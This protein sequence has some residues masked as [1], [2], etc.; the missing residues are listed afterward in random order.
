MTAMLDNGQDRHTRANVTIDT[1]QNQALIRLNKDHEDMQFVYD[2]FAKIGWLYA[3][4]HELIHIM[5]YK[6]SSLAENMINMVTDDEQNCYFRD[7]LE[8]KEESTV[9][10]LT[11]A[12]IN[13]MG[14]DWVLQYKRGNNNEAK[15]SRGCKGKED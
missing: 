8:C 6:M 4:I 5:L 2:D 7:D 11:R 14:Y 3:L 15:V 9:N 1:C 12:F 10:S 13:V